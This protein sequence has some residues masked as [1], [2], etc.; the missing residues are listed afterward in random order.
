MTAEFAPRGWLSSPITQSVLASKRPS[1]WLSRKVGLKS[2]FYQLETSEGILTGWHS[3]HPQSRYTVI[4]IHGWEGHQDSSYIYGLACRLF[5]EGYSVF[6]LNLRDH[7]G[8][9]GLNREPFHSARIQ[10]VIEA[11]QQVVALEGKPWSVVGFSL[12]GNFA[13]R[14][15]LFADR[16]SI[17]PR[18][19]IG[20]SPA[21]NPRA[22]LLGIDQGPALFR[23]YFLNKWRNTLA[24]KAQA[25]PGV[26]DFSPYENIKTFVKIT[27]QFVKDYTSYPDL[28]AY[29]DDYT[30]TPA[31]LKTSTVPLYILTAQDDSVVPFA[32]FS[33]M[34]TAIAGFIA[35]AHGGH[36]G[37]IE[38]WRMDSF[39]ERQVLAW[40][41]D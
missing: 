6:R 26:F 25:W 2:R 40:L 15:G 27:E 12:G 3:P 10:E 20:V 7:A 41:Q 29:L 11:S 31:R 9:H 38:N 24:A 34:E 22:T 1:H 17:P 18:H 28:S 36:C 5:T 19:A 8:S 35:P 16:M 23:R 39:V 33:G 37:F 4:L 30:L 14:L 21:I 13:L 32:D